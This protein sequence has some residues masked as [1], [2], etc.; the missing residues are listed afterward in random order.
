M[1]SVLCLNVL[2]GFHQQIP[3]VTIQRCMSVERDGRFR[4]TDN[5]E[6]SRI[7]VG[8]VL[9]KQIVCRLYVLVSAYIFLY[10]NCVQ[11]FSDLLLYVSCS[12]K[13]ASL[14]FNQHA[15]KRSN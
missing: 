4:E 5:F 11:L 10:N 7:N 3:R 2:L 8:S 15:I 12:Y 6:S 1:C 14:L 13:Y 9:F